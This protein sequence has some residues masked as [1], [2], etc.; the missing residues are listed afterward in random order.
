MNTRTRIAVSV[1]AGL[2]VATAL[3]GTAFALPRVLGRTA[4]GPNGMMGAPAFSRTADRPDIEEMQSFM[5]QYRTADGRIDVNRMR[6]N[7]TRGNVTP[8]CLDGTTQ[9]G[10]SGRGGATTR[11]FSGPRM[12]GR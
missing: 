8:P 12:M 4:F 10:T 11:G 6:D 5:N 3:V 2:L 9:P 7:V 1:I